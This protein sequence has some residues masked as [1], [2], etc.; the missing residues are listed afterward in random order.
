MLGLQ[1]PQLLALREDLLVGHP[2]HRQVRRVIGDGVVGVA[3]R[4]GGLQHLVERG[5][6][7][8]QVRV[9]VQVAAEVLELQDLRQLAGDRRLDLAAILPERRLDVRQPEPLVDL[10]LGLGREQVSRL[11]RRTARTRSAS[12]PA[13]TASSRIRTLCALEPVK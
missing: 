1:R 11:R 12:G 2:L 7:V 9:R 10:L 13:R 4:R 8:G 6:P 5:Q 3:Q